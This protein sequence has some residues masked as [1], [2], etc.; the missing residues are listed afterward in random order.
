MNTNGHEFIKR[1]APLEVREFEIQPNP[2]PLAFVRGSTNRSRN[3]GEN[4]RF[5]Q[6][7]GGVRIWIETTRPLAKVTVFAG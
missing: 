3:G 7:R 5:D 6:Y 4:E 1:F 2:K